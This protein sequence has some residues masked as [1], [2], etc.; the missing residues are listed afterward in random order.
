MDMADTGFSEAEQAARD[1]G[2]DKQYT[3]DCGGR[4]GGGAELSYRFASI[5]STPAPAR[6][7]ADDAAAGQQIIGFAASRMGNLAAMIGLILPSASSV[8]GVQSFFISG[9][10]RDGCRSL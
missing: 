10:P 6:H 8:K 1:D 7:I 2:R 5:T 4:Q 9:D 3:S